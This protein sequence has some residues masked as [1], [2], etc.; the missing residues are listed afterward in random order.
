[1]VQSLESFVSLLQTAGP[2]VLKQ[3]TIPQQQRSYLRWN[4]KS[5][6]SVTTA[7]FD[8]NGKTQPT[9]ECHVLQPKHLGLLPQH[10]ALELPK[11]LRKTE[12]QRANN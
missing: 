10:R 9:A 5:Y 7:T 11:L 6:N 4:W 12:L 3:V 2:S 1:M 8:R